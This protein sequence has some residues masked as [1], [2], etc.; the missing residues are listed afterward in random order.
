MINTQEYTWTQAD[1]D[2]GFLS[3]GQELLTGQSKSGMLSVGKTGHRQVTSIDAN[4]HQKFDS[5]VLDQYLGG[6]LTWDTALIH[7]ERSATP[8]VIIDTANGTSDTNLTNTSGIVPTTTKVPS[9]P[10]DETLEIERGTS[11]NSGMYTSDKIIEQ[12]AV[13][14]FD[15]VEL[16][17][18]AKGVGSF[19]NDI[20]AQSR[21]GFD[22]AFDTINYE[23]G[24]NV[25]EVLVGTN[26]QNYNAT[27]KTIM[28]TFSTVFMTPAVNNT[29]EGVV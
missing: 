25:H 8:N 15:Y 9:R 16:N 22:G 5:A 27:Y 28:E 13:E 26:E 23:S 17:S 6:G 4:D 11:G 1:G 19:S 10:Y 18:V 12:G 2:V 29:T 14:S 24:A 3:P 21:V 7:G 20:H